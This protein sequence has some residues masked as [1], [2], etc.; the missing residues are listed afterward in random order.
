MKEIR[1]SPA[2]DDHDF[3]VKVDKAKEFLSS[4]RRVRFSV[5]FRRG[6]GKYAVRLESLVVSLANALSVEYS[7]CVR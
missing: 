2:I 6:Q 5:R 4:G 7:D 1:I 3:Q